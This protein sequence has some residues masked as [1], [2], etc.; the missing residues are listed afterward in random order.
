MKEF[1]QLCKEFEQMDVL[2]YSAILAEKSAKVLPALIDIT[3]DGMDGVSVFA[4]FILGAVAADGKLAEEE[5]AVCYPLFRTFFGESVNYETCKAL[6]K[7]LKAGSKELKDE[8]D[9]MADVIGLVSE[10]LKDDLVIVCLMICA[11]DGK[12]SASEKRWIK[13]LIR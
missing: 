10:E 5:Y 11:I 2:T 13:K 8:V 12:V 3:E 4:T 7:K 9:A 1:N 6:A